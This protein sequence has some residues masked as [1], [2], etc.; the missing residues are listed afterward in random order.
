MPAPV[1]TPARRF[2]VDSAPATTAPSFSGP[3]TLV[4]SLL[5]VNTPEPFRP[6]PFRPDP[7]RP[8]NS[9]P[10]SPISN[11]SATST[12]SNRPIS[13]STTSHNSPPHSL[14]NTGIEESVQQ[15]SIHNE[16]PISEHTKSTLHTMPTSRGNTETTHVNVNTNSFFHFLHLLLHCYIP[17]QL[18]LY[19]TASL[20]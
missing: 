16:P 20:V 10:R 15:L 7:F 13:Q 6:D 14:K 17:S 1:S 11:T 5:G 18:V 8:P 9:L 3:L 12:T 4:P 19:R 2:S